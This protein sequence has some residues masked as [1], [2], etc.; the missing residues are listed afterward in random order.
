MTAKKHSVKVYAD[1]HIG[2]VREE[3]QDAYT[4]LSVHGG[5]LVVVCDGMGGEAGGRIAS[6]V[7]I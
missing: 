6:G 2:C 5:T 7:A 3:N 1:S 4:S